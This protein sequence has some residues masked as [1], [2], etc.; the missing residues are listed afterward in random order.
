MIKGL[1]MAAGKPV[2]PVSS[3]E[4]LAYNLPYVPYTVCPLIDARKK[5]MYA[6]FFQW[7]EKEE[8]FDRLTEDGLYTPQQLAEFIHSKPALGDRILFSGDGAAI[9]GGTIRSSL[10][11]RAVLLP[12]WSAIP[13]GVV[14][15]VLGYRGFRERRE[16]PADDLVPA[17]IQDF[18]RI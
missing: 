4:V 16:C 1:S 6:A 13:S 2:L 7:N 11:G 15:A 18:P 9:H 5:E 10:G 17:Y 12:P 8:R 14:V 3:L